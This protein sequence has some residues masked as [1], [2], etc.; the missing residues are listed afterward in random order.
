MVDSLIAWFVRAVHV[1]GAAIW[2]GAYAVMLLAIVPQLARGR[3]EAVRSIALAAARVISISSLV[4]VVAGL[5]MISWSRGYGFLLLF[6]E[7]G[8][9]VI[10]SAVLA[11]AMGA[12]G[13]M[14]LRPAI[15]R[16]DPDDPSSVA[17]VR[18]W[19]LV[20]LVLGVLTVMLMTRAVYARS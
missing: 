7:W 17:A 19:A 15:R 8:G 14:A 13:D 6:G 12:L 3:D 5:V 2:V 20:G 10:T 16:W 4:T 1:S 9:I 11:V 18:R